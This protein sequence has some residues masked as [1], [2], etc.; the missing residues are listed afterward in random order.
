MCR[1]MYSDMSK[2]RNCDAQHLGQLLGQLGLADAGRPGEQE[3]ADRP[4]GLA[5]AGAVHLDRRRQPLD[6]RVLTEDLRLRSRLEVV[7]PLAVV[8]LRHRLGGMRAIVATTASISFTPIVRLR[9]DSAAAA[10]APAPASSITSIALSGSR[11]S[12]R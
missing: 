5:Q 6:R 11:R 10:S 7:Q 3:A 12:L 9:F 8:G 1:S 2:R 4:L